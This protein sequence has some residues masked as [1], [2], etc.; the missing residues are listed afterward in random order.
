[1]EE[2]EKEQERLRGSGNFFESNFFPSELILF[3]IKVYHHL[4]P[5]PSHTHLIVL[6]VVPFSRSF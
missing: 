5:S 6:P 4:S 2:R 1:M 3:T